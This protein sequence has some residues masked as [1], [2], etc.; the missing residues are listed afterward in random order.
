MAIHGNTDVSHARNQLHNHPK[1]RVPGGFAP[2][3]GGGSRVKPSRTRVLGIM[4]GRLGATA[5]G[6]TRASR[7]KGAPRFKNTMPVQSRPHG[8]PRKTGEQTPGTPARFMSRRS[9]TTRG[10]LRRQ[11]PNG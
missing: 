6:N 1:H 7:S 8:A 5:S 9:P 4:G 10:D 3:Q 2:A 11:L